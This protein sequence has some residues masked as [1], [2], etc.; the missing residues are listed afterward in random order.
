MLVNSVKEGVLQISSYEG[1][2]V[3]DARELHEKLEVATRF[4]DWI[5]YR[6]KQYDLLEGI[7]YQ[8]LSENSVKPDGGRP[9]MNF[10]LSLNCATQLAMVE[11]NERGK[12]I[13]RYFIEIEKEFRRR[14]EPIGTVYPIV[15]G[16]KVG[17]PRSELLK[18]AGYSTKS[19]SVSRLKLRYPA[20][21][22]T[23]GGVACYTPE[24]AKLRYEQGRVR[25]MELE[26]FAE[27]RV[28]AIA[29]LKH[30]EE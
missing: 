8:I 12:Q 30:E 24:L 6:I 4:N 18:Q 28:S 2:Q 19:G 27:Q 25:Q 16:D 23:I 1:Q 15:Q 13:R 7:D 9:A 17:Y 22:L 29:N 20:G 26:L 11:N 5:G 21:H 3:V 14:F 10:A